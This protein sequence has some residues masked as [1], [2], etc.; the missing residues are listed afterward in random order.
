MGNKIIIEPKNFSLYLEIERLLE[1]AGWLK[2]I[3]MYEGFEHGMV[4]EFVKK[5]HVNV[6]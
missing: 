5:I 3:K 1:Q 2:L 4:E 6:T